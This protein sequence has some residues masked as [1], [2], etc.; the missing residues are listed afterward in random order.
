ATTRVGRDRREA[1]AD[2]QGLQGTDDRRFGV[3]GGNWRA[4]AGSLGGPE[5][6]GACGVFDASLSRLLDRGRLQQSGPQSERG[7]A[8]A[9]PCGT[10]NAICVAA[11]H[12]SE[13]L[14]LCTTRA[15]R[16]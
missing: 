15:T 4:G 7:Q 9:F 11:T 8:L 3:R 6:A 2:G 13:E 14:S 5:P 16:I 12:G 10:E 1:R